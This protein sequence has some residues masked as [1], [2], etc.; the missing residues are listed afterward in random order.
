MLAVGVGVG[1]GAA[2]GAGAGTTGG[3]APIAIPKVGRTS[4]NMA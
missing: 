2:E 4:S 3:N 1:A